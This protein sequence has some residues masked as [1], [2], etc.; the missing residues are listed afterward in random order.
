MV[1]AHYLTLKSLKKEF[2]TQ[3]KS[4]LHKI[5]QFRYVTKRPLFYPEFN[6]TTH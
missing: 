2:V 6:T 5:I 3:N 1:Q 4:M